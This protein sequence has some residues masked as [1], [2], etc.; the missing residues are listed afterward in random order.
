MITLID[1]SSLLWRCLLAGEDKENGYYVTDEEGKERYVNTATYGY[2]NAASHISKMMTTLGIT[3][4]QMVLVTEGV[5]G[6]QLR[7]S[8]FK[9]YK[10]GRDKLS[11]TYKE[12]N[13]LEELFVNDMLNLGA[14]C[15]THR[16]VEADDVIAW[17]CENLHTPTVVIS[18]DKDL[19]QC[20]KHPHVKVWIQD[21]VNPK[22]FGDFPFEFIDVYKATVGDP[23]DKIPG[24]RG[25]GQKAFEAVYAA[26]GDNGLKILRKGIETKILTRLSENVKQVPQLQ[27]LIDYEP[28]VYTSLRLAKFYTNEVAEGTLQWRHGMNGVHTEVHPLLQPWKQKVTGVT[29]E[30][31]AEVCLKIKQQIED[32][33]EISLDIE[34]YTTEDSDQW[35]RDLK[36]DDKA[37]A[38]SV[39][40]HG[41]LLAGVGL[42]LG[43][44]FQH[45]YYFSVQHAETGNV[46]LEQM[47]K[48][49]REL[50]ETHRF[51]I[52]NVNFELPV[53]HNVFGF[54][55][56]DVDDTKLMAS[57]IDEN[58]PL[59]LKQN[60]KRYLC[61]DQ[62]TYEET[63]GLSESG[64]TR[65][66]DELTLNEVL[67]YGADDTI[68]T[69]ALYTWYKLKLQLEKVFDIYRM[70]E[71]PAAYWVAQAFVDGV[72]ID[73]GTLREM[74]L[75]DAEAKAD[76]QQRLDNYLSQHGWEGTT[77]ERATDETRETP[78]WIK[79]AF[80]IV[81]GVPL[82]CNYRRFD[83]VLEAVRDQAKTQLPIFL[84][85]A[86]TQALNDFVASHFKGTPDFNAGSPK[87]VQKLLYEVMELPI[88][89]RNKPTAIMLAAGKREGTPQTDEL[90]VESALHYDLTDKDDPRRE[91]LKA[92][93]EL[94]MYNTREGL[95]YKTYPFLPHW[96]DGKIHASNNQSSTVTRRF[97]C[98]NP[99][100]AQLS[101][102]K[103]DF[104][105]IFVP[106]HKDALIVSLDFSAQELR[107]TASA[108]GDE[109]MKACYV[110]DDLRDLHSMTASGI[111]N[112]PYEEFMKILRDPSHERHKEFKDIRK[113]AKVVNFAGLY[114][115]QA[116]TMS[117]NL[118]C[119]EEEAQSYI[120]AKARVFAR[121][122]EWKREVENFAAEHGYSQTMLGVRRHL[123]NINSGDNAER[124]R[125]ERQAVNFVIQGSAAEQTK[126]AMGRIWEADLRNKYDMRF[127]SPIHD[128]LVFSIAKSDMP[129]VLP[130]L[131]AAMT[132][133]YA[134]MTV[135]ADSS[136]SFGVNFGDQHEMSEFYE[137]GVKPTPDNVRRMIEEL[138]L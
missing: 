82:Q 11:E 2:D 128:E 41:S 72:D 46:T 70:V 84:A 79:M 25:F 118:M 59:G 116:K 7:A 56:R 80:Q 47:G 93:L 123:T 100:L 36:G 99:N 124:S 133:Q 73:M 130:K 60:S 81:E 119:T 40:V 87:Q 21:Q 63:V 65:K 68:C 14:Q 29:A 110:G 32:T 52:Q 115:S 57:Y 26:F 86:D 49:L 127:I 45:T 51:I 117:H 103:G 121:V 48:L 5:G 71:I 109:G 85:G 9:E 54:W 10:A 17:F 64:A 76:A 37:A 136:I 50:N 125:N 53:L 137:D 12:Y 90:A 78:A 8:F 15:V 129:D 122:E 77:F 22:L 112:L 138:G 28:D 91:A 105:R 31:F 23:S 61:Y 83:R 24:A 102:S 69:A 88:R 107:L 92:L 30:N 132:A 34:T 96:K 55:L 134:D 98:S 6:K 95:Y 20:A 104:R 13:Q 67:A 39:D 19:L 1:V 4:R 66:M 43:D 94:K 135:P 18:H 131:Y 58:S 97:S 126:L 89:L 75:R 44:N 62:A 3:P 113:T 108:S 38:K 120:D 42:T 101:K 33:K 114:G 111:A 27:K 16:G 35:L 106:H 74:I